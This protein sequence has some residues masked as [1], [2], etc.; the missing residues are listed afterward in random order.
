MKLSTHKHGKGIK[1]HDINQ[2][3]EARIMIEGKR[4]T[5][6]YYDTVDEAIQAYENAK[7]VKTNSALNFLRS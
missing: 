7:K 4:I 3:W 1:F 5:L 6:G 2:K